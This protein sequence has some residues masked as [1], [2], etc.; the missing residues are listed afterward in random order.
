MIGGRVA[1][2]SLFPILLL[3]LRQDGRFARSLDAREMA[4]YV[5]ANPVY[6]TRPLTVELWARLNGAQGYNILIANE[7]KAS[8]THWEIFTMPGSG[9]LAAYLPGNKPPQFEGR[10]SLHDG[11]WHYLAMVT[12]ERSVRLYVDGK[13]EA[14]GE[15]TR[16]PDLQPVAAPMFF[17]SLVE[18][19]L[20]CDGAIAEVRL[21]RIARTIEGLPNGPLEADENT[22]GLWRFSEAPQEGKYADL[23]VTGNPAT[24]VR[25]VPTL[26]RIDVTKLSAMEAAEL[27]KR[28][29]QPGGKSHA[30]PPPEVD[31]AKT[32]AEFRAALDALKLPSL[33]NASQ[34]RD[35]VLFDWEEQYYRLD[36]RLTGRERPPANAEMQVLDPQALVYP[37]DGDPLGVVLRRTEALADHVLM[38]GETRK[39]WG[40]H[41][42]PPEAVAGK[43][44]RPTVLVPLRASVGRAPTESLKADLA[45]LRE[46][47]AKVDVK[48]AQARKRLFLAACALQREIAF[49]NPLLDFDKILFVARGNYL[50]SRMTGPTTTADVYGQHFATQYYGFNS[51]PGGGL[52]CVEDYKTEPKV[53]NVLADSVVERGRLTGRKLEPGAFLSPDLSF[54]GKTIAFAHTENREHKWVW[55]PQTTWNLFRVNVDGS[56]LQQLTDSQYDDFDPCW[57]PNGR[58]AFIS[59]RRGGYIRCFAL[60]QVPSHVLHSMQADGS[61]IIPLSYYETSEWQPSVNND[62]MLV[63]T[64]W[65]YTDRE[66]CLGSQFWVCYPDGRDPRAPHGNYPYPWHTFED[67]TKGDSRDG[68][69]YAEMNIRAIPDSHRYLM[70][71]APH[72]GEAFGSLVMLDLREP[73]D[74]NMSQLKR[75]TPYVPFPET[76]FAGRS[77]YEFGTPW[78]L[79]EDFYLCNWWENLYLLDRFGNQVLLCENALVFGKTNHDMR[80]IDPIPVKPRPTAPVIATETNQGEDADPG[81]PTATIRLMNVYDADFPFPEGAKI[82]WLRVTQNIL[83]LNPWMGVPMIG[84]QNENTPRIALGIVPVEEDG[85]AYFEA[86]VERE[87]IFQALDENHMAVQSMRSVAFV[88]PGEQLTCQGCHESPHKS[89]T[90]SD[91]PSALQRP[92]SKLQPEIGAVEPVSYYRTVKP[93]FEQSCLPCHRQQGKGP[94]DMSYEALEPYVFYFAGGMSRTTTKPIHGGSRTIPGRFGARNCRMGKAL[95]D[96]NHRGRISESDYLRVVLWLDSNSQRLGAYHDVER[97][98]AGELVWPTLDVDPANPQGLERR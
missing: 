12:D 66:N 67:N 97:Q 64:R 35:A 19:G 10:T 61:D 20:S 9:V 5:A 27:D 14:G 91:R 56:G 88:H 54:D 57:L 74:G 72:H 71:A 15:V 43:N 63:Y 37:I 18:R 78:P 90:L 76:E 29:Q 95:L 39:Q 4:A 40:G 51:I 70:T 13:Q 26:D 45:K 58:I 38:L 24:C 92:P 84:Y 21:S 62:G 30:I 94:V 33:A 17:G 59:E 44:A 6:N 75:I 2:L 3:P 49:A 11:K 31:L 53:V 48:D 23:S 55:S 7:T 82:K 34:T 79:S 98:L 86:P 85:S 89:V 77:Q 1:A 25:A 46:A 83:K 22:I 96:E 87:L 8:P 42:C 52:Y 32:R 73:D 68:R 50:G 80:L 93:V 60:L 41:S 16:P 69:P 81:K 47:A 28:I 65:D 36:L